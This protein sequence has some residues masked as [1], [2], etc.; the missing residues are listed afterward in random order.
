MFSA[1]TPLDDAKLDSFDSKMLDGRLETAKPHA[2]QNKVPLYKPQTMET[3]CNWTLDI[4]GRNSP[5]T[6]FYLNWGVAESL[7]AA[8]LSASFSARHALPQGLSLLMEIE[9]Q[10]RKQCRLGIHCD[11]CGLMR[12]T[13]VTILSYVMYIVLPYTDNI[14]NLLDTQLIYTHLNLS[15]FNASWRYDWTIFIYIPQ[16]QSLGRQEPLRRRLTTKRPAGG[17]FELSTGVGPAASPAGS[18]VMRKLDW[19]LCMLLHELLTNGVSICM[20]LCSILIF[21]I[22][23]WGKWEINYNP[24][25]V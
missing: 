16:F 12:R 22:F 5:T 2:F 1:A 10:A 19:W 20:Y 23:F 4:F 6:N 7:A 13:I 24:P 8:A 14:W 17:P 15:W 21:Y 11:P 18:W 25:G 3:Y 9:N